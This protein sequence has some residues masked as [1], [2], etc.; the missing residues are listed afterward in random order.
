MI[1]DEEL[2]S[3]YGC[4]DYIWCKY[5]LSNEISSGIFGRAYQLG[6][7]AIVREGSYLDSLAQH[8]IHPTVHNIDF[9]LGDSEPKRNEQMLSVDNHRRDLGMASHSLETINA[10]LG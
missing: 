9:E 7:V 3:L 4:A 1:S 6:K 2:F 5:A 8:I 10:S